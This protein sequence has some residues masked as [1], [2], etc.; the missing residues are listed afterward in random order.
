MMIDVGAAA[1]VI[2]CGL[3]VTGTDSCSMIHL[4]YFQSLWPLSNLWIKGSG[5]HA[6]MCIGLVKRALFSYFL[7]CTAVSLALPQE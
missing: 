4:L 2:F 1:Y 3:F 7:F 6:C 5:E